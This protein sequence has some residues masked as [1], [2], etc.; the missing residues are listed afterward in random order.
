MISNEKAFLG[1]PEEFHSKFLIY[2]PLVRDVIGNSK[3][4]QYHQM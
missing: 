4:P 3:F 1:Y 2:P